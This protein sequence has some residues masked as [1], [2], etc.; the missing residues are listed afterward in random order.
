[1]KLS[2]ARFNAHLRHMGQ[3][4][5][6][7]RAYSCPC[8]DPYSGA[9]K[10]GCSHCAGKGRL[11][12]LPIA[13]HVGIT[14]MQRQRQWAQM[15]LWESGDVVVSLPSD[16][17]LYGLGEADRVLFTDSSNAFSTV[18]IRGRTD[19]A[20]P[21][22]IVQL[23]RLFWLDTARQTVELLLPQLPANVPFMQHWPTPGDLL[24]NADPPLA[25]GQSYS[26]TG[27]YCPEYFVWSDLVQDRHHHDGL[28]L[29]RHVVLRR[30]D[31]FG[32]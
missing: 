11:W 23:D 32:R 21:W 3:R 29:P 6:W 12:T 24:N 27:R 20:W 9:A 22:E 31:L 30:F 25:L 5:Q 26:V 19:D 17:P 8:R 4:V 1:M 16:T 14:G 7:R 28:N 13:G 15:G 18:L 2:P 10:P